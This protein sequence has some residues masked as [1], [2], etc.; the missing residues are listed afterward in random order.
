MSEAFVFA[1]PNREYQKL[2]FTPIAVT[3]SPRIRATYTE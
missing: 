1:D 2:I 3:R